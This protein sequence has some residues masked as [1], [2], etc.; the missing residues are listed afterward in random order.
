MLMRRKGARERMEGVER[1]K[2]NVRFS[3][4]GVRDTGSVLALVGS[5][6]LLL[7]L[8]AVLVTLVST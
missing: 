4:L 5:S 3:T 6:Q 8:E 2:V 7:G 1:K